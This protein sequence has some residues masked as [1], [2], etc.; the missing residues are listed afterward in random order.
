MCEQCV[1]DCDDLGYV[2]R[3]IGLLKAKRDGDFMKAGQYGLVECN[4]PFCLFDETPY[5]DP[6]PET[7]DTQNP[8]ADAWILSAGR[9]RDKLIVHPRLGHFIVESCKSSGYNPETDGDVAMWLFDRAGKLI[10][11]KELYG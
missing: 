5:P 3:N 11:G 9:F 4:D 1:A 2:A 8:A 7:T 10:E 6:D